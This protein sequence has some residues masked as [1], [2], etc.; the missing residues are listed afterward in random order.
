MVAP[1]RCP[2]IMLTVVLSAL[3]LLALG[4]EADL[5]SHWAFDEGTGAAASDSQ[6]LHDGTLTAISS[7]QPSWT[8]DSKVGDYALSFVSGDGHIVDCGANNALTSLAGAKA[9]TFW[10][11]PSTAGGSKGFIACDSNSST[12][13]WYVDDNNNGGKLR[14]Y[15]SA[16]GPAATLF[17]IP[18]AITYESWQHVA[19][20][21][22]G[23]TWDVY[24]DGTALTP[25]GGVGASFDLSEL[26][27]AATFKIGTARFSTNYQSYQGVMDDVAVWDS[28]LSATDVKA[29]H[30]VG[31]NATLNCNA[32]QAGQLLDLFAA[33]SGHATVGNHL[34]EHAT[35]LSGT[36]GVVQQTGDAFALPLDASGNGLTARVGLVGHWTFDEGSGQMANDSAGDTHGTLGATTA[37]GSDDPTWSSGKLGGALD[38]DGSDLVLTGTDSAITNLS[39]PKTFSL[40]ANTDAGRANGFITIN[41]GTANNRWYLDDNS[42]GNDL[43]MY[44]VVGGSGATLLTSSGDA[45]N[46]GVWQ[47]IVVVD[48]GDHWTAY[49]DGEVATTSASGSSFD[50]SAYPQA[51]TAF[52][53]GRARHSGSPVPLGGKLDDVAVW[54]V[55]L[56]PERVKAVYS[57]ADDP[58]L[59]YDAGKAQEL[60]NV[61][62]GKADKAVLGNLFWEA[63]SGLKG[64]PGEVTRH[65]DIVSVDLDGAGN[66]VRARLGLIGHWT[67]DEGSGQVA[68]DSAGNTHGTLGADAA[69][70]TDDPTWTTG[71]LGGALDFDGSDLVLTGT[72]S[73]I[74]NLSGPKTF[75]LWANTDAGHANGFIT[76]NDG[77]A[78][79]RWYLDD[80][81]NANDL[82]MYRA[83]GG[84][85]GTEVLRTSNDALND[86]VWQHIVVVDD[87]DRWT[88][89]L[90]GEV[91]ATGAAG[92]SFDFSAFPQAATAFKMGRA[93]HSSNPVPLYGKLDDVAVWNL[94]LSPTRVRALYGLGDN[95]AL[96]Y[97]AG[98]AQRLFNFFDDAAD[99]RSDG[100]QA[101]QRVTGLGGTPGQVQVLPSGRR[102]VA[103]DG[104]GNG[105]QMWSGL[106]GHWAFDGAATD[107]VAGNDGALVGNPQWV[108]GRLGGALAFDGND[109]VACGGDNLITTLSTTKTFSFWANVQEQGPGETSGYIGVDNN[110]AESRWYVDDNY[111]GDGAR[112]YRQAGPSGVVEL[113]TS[114]TAPDDSWNHFVVVDDGSSWKIFVNGALEAAGGSSFDFTE[115]ALDSV[116]SIGRVRHAG[117]ARYML[118]MMDDIGAWNVA[119]SDGQAIALF[120]LADNAFFGY[121][122]AEAQQLFDLYA[123]GAGSLTLGGWVWGPADG[124]T[125]DLGVATRIGDDVYLRLDDNGGGL[126]TFIPEPTTFALLAIGLP[127]LLRR[128]KQR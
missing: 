96:S 41:D 53:M 48:D 127:A 59:A 94:A 121:D 66:G 67:F 78:A 31:D 80:I 1:N 11:K 18:N 98:Q 20:V 124:L 3:L 97:D 4:A 14:S 116:F 126:K 7:G 36:P 25:A 46:D 8:T 110:T 105:V 74:T 128:R 38:F 102:A 56:S 23:S 90:D 95:A 40:W 6:G 91:A 72:D 17:D 93:R 13:R 26:S 100:N 35:G 79:N 77:T 85:P 47:H 89:Y 83:V 19:V 55:A 75:S 118:G 32:A 112:I 29:I 39:G 109:Y 92:S 34:W 57:V 69:A 37:T 88:A 117:E 28:G 108:A 125:T 43:R 87:G 119:L 30:S 62:D 111:N 10:A 65:G 5:L 114:G 123:A 120:S 64:T 61:A 33:G 9:F 68:G 50:F 22:N 16:G 122:V 63:A 15:K 73:A 58:A 103:L 24:V 52:K 51:A 12:D 84:D 106:I 21:D 27:T 86:G 71:K 104:S 2:I 115:L 44:R 82:R 70:D 42:N 76:V 54:N 81:G 107:A 45:L 60:L 113:S 49:L 101:W 99:N